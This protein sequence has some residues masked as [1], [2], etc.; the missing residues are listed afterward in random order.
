MKKKFFFLISIIIGGL[1][2]TGVYVKLGIKE[3]IRTLSIFS[4]SEFIF[5]F[6]F[7]SLSTLF[8]TIRWKYILNYYNNFNIPFLK[9]L[10]IKLSGFA[11]SYLTPVIYIGGEPFRALMLKS[12]TQN[13]LFKCFS[14]VY[15]DKIIEL[16]SIVLLFVI[17]ALLVFLKSDPPLILKL[18]V[19]IVLLISISLTYF[20]FI[21][22]LKG[23]STLSLITKILKI[24]KLNSG[25]E[26]AEDLTTYYFKNKKMLLG[27]FCLSFLALG[28]WLIGYWLTFYYLKIDIGLTKLLIVIAL[29]AAI[30]F[31]PIPA[32]LGVYET[33]LALIFP[34]LGLPALKGVAFTLIWR[35]I[36]LILISFGFLY[37]VHFNSK[38]LH[39]NIKTN[40]KY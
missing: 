16:L 13:R 34:I 9:L 27:S 24:K 8:H 23:K 40:L 19:L 36:N 26:K 6:I 14:S 29:N 2:F 20:L 28:F 37:F 11:F 30:F 21:R 32:S 18:G 31:I 10:G 12:L 15:I 25:L 4:I 35:A 33:G 1:I 39:H 17:G 38:I 3:I 22:S 5:I 7:A